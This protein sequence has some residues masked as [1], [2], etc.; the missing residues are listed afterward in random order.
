MIDVVAEDIS[1]VTVETDSGTE[2]Q[3]ITSNN[4][5]QVNISDAIFIPVSE[6]SR[7]IFNEIMIGEVDGENKIFFFEDLPVQGKQS[8]FLNGTF[9]KVNKEDGSRY[10]YDLF[11][12]HIEF[13]QAPQATDSGDD[14]VIT[15][16]IKQ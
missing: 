1:V 4:L 13:I 12:D 16:Y 14:E 7:F 9:Q 11:D 2:V 8:I 5:V 3:V 10:D 6:T 15:N